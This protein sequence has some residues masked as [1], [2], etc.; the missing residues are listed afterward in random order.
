MWRLPPKPS[1][2][3]VTMV[4]APDESSDECDTQSLTNSITDYPIENGRRYHKYHEGLY[5]YPN[6]EQELDR[7]DMQHHLFKT[8]HHGRI[9]FSPVQNPLRILDI[10]TGSGIWP[11]ELVQPTVVPENVHFLIDDATENDWL[12]NANHFD[13]IHTGHL[14][15]SLP[16]FK[17]MMEKAFHHLRPGG[18][19]ECHEIDPKPQCDDGTM[20]PE[21]P[22]GPSEY[23][24]HDWFYYHERSSQV[25]DPPRPFRIAHNIATWMKEVGFVDVQEIVTKIPLNTWPTDPVQCEIGSWSEANWLDGLAGW[26]YKPFRDLGWSIAEI[27][28]FLVNVRKSIQNRNVHAYHNL[29][30][31]TG[32]KPRP[33]ET[34]S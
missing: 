25:I 15:G 28:V 20:P 16:S 9:F 5:R 30:V 7:M 31:V 10:G 32:R 2:P 6:D 26:S 11:I 24:L 33:G 23:A 4:S 34:S 22:D 13:L 14:S 8:V 27:E 19:L 29:Y 3:T 17:D 21:N 1:V 18:Y 12:W